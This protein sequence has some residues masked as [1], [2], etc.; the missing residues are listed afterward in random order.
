MPRRYGLPSVYAAAAVATAVT[1]VAPL[2][3]TPASGL[4]ARPIVTE[5]TRAYI[6]TARSRGDAR[7]IVSEARWRVRRFYTA[8]LP[9][10]ATW[11]NDTEAAELRAD[12]RVRSL[13]LDRRVH[14]MTSAPVSEAGGETRSRTERAGPIGWGLDRLDERKLPLDGRF[15]SAATGRGV[16]VY[17]LDTGV[18]VSHREF[19]DRAWRAF[20]AVGPRAARSVDPYDCEGHGTHVAGIVAGRTRG[21]A[22]QAR[23]ASVRVF[24]CGE[25]A[26]MSDVI[27][28]V[29]WVRGHAQG[30]A[31]ANLSVGGPASPALDAAVRNLTRS[32]VFVVAAAGN[33]GRDACE[34]SPAR[35]GF[36]VA[37]SDEDDQRLEDSDTGPCVDLYAPGDEV[38]SA[39]PS[40]GARKGRGTSVAAPF[41]AGVA[42]LYLESHRD[43][44]PPTL[45]SWLKSTA[46]RGAIRQNPS[47]TPN[48]LLH[49]GGL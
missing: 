25:S 23:V 29:D 7:A 26:S 41:V 35:K 18:D 47:G 22:P 49:V 43:A 39:W 6:V 21:V 33:A 8:A 19:G 14:P 13:E 40:Q 12:A 24:G 4:A 31:V 17:V 44:R 15:R 42:A 11:L 34:M 1:T 9:G 36:A 45:A 32:G 16:T 20:D 38:V 46:T 28:G 2:A 30:P 3:V 10:F 5:P 27:A 37:A 48:L